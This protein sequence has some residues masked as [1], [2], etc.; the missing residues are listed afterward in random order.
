VKKALIAGFLTALLAAGGLW[1]RADTAVSGN[2]NAVTYAPAFRGMMHGPAALM[3]AHDGQAFGSLALDPL[4][5]HPERWAGADGRAQMAYRASRPLLGWLVAATSFGS[6]PIAA[7]TLVVW[8]GIGIGVLAAAAYF[9]AAAWRRQADWAPLLLFLPGVFGQ[10]LFPGLSDALATGLALAG[11]ALWL[12]RRDRWAVAAL[13]L[14]ALGR[15]TTL[16]VPMALILA[17][18]SRRTA[19]LL[20]P[21]AVYAAWIGVVWIRLGA[22]PN[23][24][25]QGHLG[26]P[27]VGLAQAIPRWSWVAAAGA[28]SVAAL[29]AAAWWRAPGREIRIL[30][31][32]SALFALAM[33]YEVWRSWDF[34][35]IL[36]PVTI[37]G[38][39]LLAVPTR[40]EGHEMEEPPDGLPSHVLAG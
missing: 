15:E 18:P 20:L 28:L 29:A 2:A 27:F 16:L 40:P 17:A 23:Q 21:L 39:C 22:L 35:R 37:V 32:L 24:A 30:V 3:N 12:E 36:L 14:A 6:A 38:A 19:R 1:L 26:L 13:C 31:V 33:P 5:A 9:L 25:S 11:V 4:L 34:A 7:W 8:S 10:I